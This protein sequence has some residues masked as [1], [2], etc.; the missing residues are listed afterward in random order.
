M[1]KLVQKATTE[2]KAALEAALRAAIQ[3]GSLPEAPLPPIALE[4]PA[5]H[6]HGDWA[7]NAAMAGARSFRLP[8]R[9]IAEAISSH[10]DLGSTY[11]DR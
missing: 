10:L 9:K 7:C 6:S 1:S 5:D 2:L 4:V 3:D 11:F 8:P